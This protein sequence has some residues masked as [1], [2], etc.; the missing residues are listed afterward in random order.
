MAII[1]VTTPF[2]IDLEFKVA[3][4]NK[5]VLAW[6]IDIIVIC[7]YYYAMLRFI[8]PLLGLSESVSSIAQLFVIIIPVLLYQ[9]GFEL[10]FNGQTIGKMA[11]GIKVIDREGHEPTWGQYIIRWMLCLG[12]LFVYTVPYV[13]L[14][15]P[16]VMIGFMVLYLPDFLSVV[17]SSQSQRIGDFAAGTVVIDKNYKSDITDTIYLPVAESGYTPMFPEVMKLSDRDI[18]GIRNLLDIK[19]PSKDT[20]HYMV[21]VAQKIK[22]VLHIESTLHPRDFLHQLLSD[23]NYYTNNNAV[24]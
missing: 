15:S 7:L 3:A 24:G 5:R 4:F 12:N 19:R 21:D 16:W 17:I 13:I 18:N 14:R 2:N 11:A 8:Y 1:T 20:E 9:L 23:Y 10:L 22:G 6:L